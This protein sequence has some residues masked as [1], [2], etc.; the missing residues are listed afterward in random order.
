M[1]TQLFVESGPNNKYQLGKYLYIFPN[2]EERHWDAIRDETQNKILFID[3]HEW[4]EQ[5]YWAKNRKPVKPEQ[6]RNNWWIPVDENG[7]S[8]FD[9]KKE[10]INETRDLIKQLQDI[11]ISNEEAKK[12]K[13]DDVGQAL[14]NDSQQCKDYIRRLCE[15]STNVFS[16]NVLL[17]SWVEEDTVFENDTKISHS[18]SISMEQ[19][20]NPL[21][22]EALAYWAL[23]EKPEDI[24]DIL[25]AIGTS[26]TK[27][28]STQ[29]ETIRQFLR[30]RGLYGQFPKPDL[31]RLE[32]FKFSAMPD[33]SIYV[34][35]EEI[36]DKF[37]GL[38]ISEMPDGS[39]LV[40]LK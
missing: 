39:F 3:E 31:P 8:L 21:P 25:D 14:T 17:G 36:V 27:F 23:K 12:S 16:N 2:N 33:G 4:K 19:L 20:I 18:V 35:E 5:E 40:E 28:Q 1:P 37:N 15:N 11:K 9:Y 32:N 38:K 30:E 29:F 13:Q 6:P 22:I 26:T 7:Y 24:K 34:E 10:L